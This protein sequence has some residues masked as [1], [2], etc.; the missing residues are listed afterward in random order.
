MRELTDEQVLQY[1]NAMKYGGEVQAIEQSSGGYYSK[2]G[3]Y[4]EEHKYTYRLPDGTDISAD[5]MSMFMRQG[6]IRSRLIFKP[7]R[8]E[9]GAM[10]HDERPDVVYYITPHAADWLY[11][12][13][14]CTVAP[15][16]KELL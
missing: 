6:A 12:L 4:I 16:S 8:R 10:V 13:S 7:A 1:L 2:E 14:R 9:P 5:L 15:H 11:Q 3:Y